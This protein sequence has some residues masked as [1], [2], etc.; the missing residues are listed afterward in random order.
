[1]LV[2]YQR[3]LAPI[4]CVLSDKESTDAVELGVEDQLISTLSNLGLALLSIAAMLRD[5]PMETRMALLYHLRRRSQVEISSSIETVQY[6]TILCANIEILSPDS[7][8]SSGMNLNL[9]GLLIRMAQDLGLHRDISSLKTS[10]ENVNRRSRIW[11]SC[12]IVDRW[13]SISYGQP[14]LIN[15]DD[16]D[17]PPPSPYADNYEGGKTLHGLAKPHE[18]HVEHIKLSALIARLLRL[19]FTPAGMKNTSIEDMQSLKR[20][21]D[22]WTDNLPPTLRLLAR[23]NIRQTSIGGGLLHLLKVA[24]DFIYYRA[25]SVSPCY[26][27][28]STFMAPPHVWDDIVKRSAEAIDWIATPDGTSILDA[29][30]IAM[31]GMIQC[32]L[33]QFYATIDGRDPEPLR[34]ARKCLQS[35]GSSIE[36]QSHGYYEP[37]QGDEP[38]SSSKMTAVQSDDAI[39]KGKKSL[40]LRTKAYTVVAMLAGIADHHVANRNNRPLE[41]LSNGTKS[42][43]ASSKPELHNFSSLTNS[44]SIPT[45][46]SSTSSSSSPY[47]FN[48]VLNHQDNVASLSMTN[49]PA[50]I[51]P[52]MQQT[53]SSSSLYP[54]NL[55]N[56]NNLLS[57]T[58]ISPNY[59]GFQTTDIE[60]IDLLTLQRWADEIMGESSHL[61]I[62]LFSQQQQQ[63]QQQHYL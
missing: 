58:G 1:M 2:K 54:S 27:N 63:S 59:T 50:S 7:N 22:A 46:L 43:M 52:T 15:S 36:T 56:S 21:L 14:C 57:S 3:F 5:T 40:T 25:A 55:S 31:Y 17:A 18:A 24:V 26:K 34:V 9:T 48:S 13:Y 37:T 38:L 41:T 6:L 47:N 8:A 30:S 12:V 28:K 4:F 51:H 29:W 49:C 33:V 23:P 16:C 35:W 60:Q 53:P 42:F 19:V 39:F 32:C 44:T 10:N 11:A 61:D 62:N 45:S 20:D